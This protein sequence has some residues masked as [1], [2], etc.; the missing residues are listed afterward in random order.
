MAS[1]R[2]CAAPD[3]AWSVEVRA[4]G[5]RPRPPSRRGL[6]HRAGAVSLVRRAGE[7]LTAAGA[8]PRAQLVSG[9]DALTASERRV[10]DLST[11]ELT[12]SRIAQALF[13]TP[14][15][16]EFHLRHVYQK[17]DIPGRRELATTLAGGQAE[18]D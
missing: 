2:R 15:T 4:P 6:A 17:L 14:K 10:A 11:Q 12:N 18:P 16:I 3:V 8:W 1:G 5:A 9:L 7:E 13:V